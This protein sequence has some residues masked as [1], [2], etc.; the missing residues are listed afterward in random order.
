QDGSYPYTAG[1]F[2]RWQSALLAHGLDT[3]SALPGVMYGLEVSLSGSNV[4]LSRGSAVFSPTGTN[5]GSYVGVRSESG[6]VATLDAADQL[7]ER[8]DRLVA[9]VQDPATTGG[10][11]RGVTTEYL[12]G[13]PNEPAPEV[14]DGALPLAQ[15]VVPAGSGTPS[16]LDERDYSGVVG[17]TIPCRSTDRPPVVAM[18][19]G[20]TI[21]ETDTGRVQ[22]WSGTSWE[23]VGGAVTILGGGVDLNTIRKPGAYG[24]PTSND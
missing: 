18:R 4:L 19:P 20:Q 6:Q 23:T 9:V 14:P 21:Y 16:V 1:D 15:L 7:Y 2:R 3:I 22:V 17:G 8:R 5:D 24:Q 12:P 11:D 13:V 10:S